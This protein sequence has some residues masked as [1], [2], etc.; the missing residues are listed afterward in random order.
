MARL[1][2]IRS[3][4]KRGSGGLILPASDIGTRVHPF[5][6]CSLG[7]DL[8]IGHYAVIH[9]ARA[10]RRSCHAWKAFMSA[11]VHGRGPSA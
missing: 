2:V 8:I 1:R 3:L 5:T 9:S 7:L 4:M 11:I 10:T 6:T